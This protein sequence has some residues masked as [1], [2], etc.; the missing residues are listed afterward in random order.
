M[1]VIDFRDNKNVD[2]S[3]HVDAGQITDSLGMDGMDARPHEMH[4]EFLT[5]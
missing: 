1:G 3:M 5:S 4:L 2:S